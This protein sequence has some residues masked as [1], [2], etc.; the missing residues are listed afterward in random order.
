MGNFQKT[1]G[2]KV[3]TASQLLLLDSDETLGIKEHVNR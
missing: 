2:S 1:F 3:I